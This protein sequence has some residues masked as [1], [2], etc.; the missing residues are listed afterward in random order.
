MKQYKEAQKVNLEW[1]DGYF[2]IGKYYDKIM[3]KLAW[4]KKG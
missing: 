2:Y 4:E 3:V 1:E